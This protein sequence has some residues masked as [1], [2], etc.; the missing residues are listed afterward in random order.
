[1]IKITIYSSKGEVLYEADFSDVNDGIRWA[2][3]VFSAD[4]SAAN[5]VLET[6]ERQP[7]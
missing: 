1:M 5:F 7:A 3:G 4:D 2:D 6:I